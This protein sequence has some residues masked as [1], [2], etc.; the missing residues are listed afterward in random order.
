MTT[1]K[2]RIHHRQQTQAHDDSPQRLREMFTP[3][4]LERRA[5]ARTNK[6]Q[7]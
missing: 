4:A 5:D 3:A 6:L 2:R 1:S 7:R